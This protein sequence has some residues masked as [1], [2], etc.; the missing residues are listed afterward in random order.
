MPFLVFFHGYRVYFTIENFANSQF[1]ALHSLLSALRSPLTYELSP[2]S[3]QR[4]LLSDPKVHCAHQT[5]KQQRPSF[6]PANIRLQHVQQKKC[7]PIC[8]LGSKSTLGISMVYPPTPL[9]NTSNNQTQKGLAKNRPPHKYSRIRMYPWVHAH[10]GGPKS[11]SKV[12]NSFHK[13]QEFAR[14]LIGIF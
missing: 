10:Y 1:C 7:P 11:L 6:V 3:T 5:F 8:T 14:V 13:Y 9:I 2:Y 12:P 4:S